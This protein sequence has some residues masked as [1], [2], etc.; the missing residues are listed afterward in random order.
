MTGATAKVA[1]VRLRPPL[2]APLA[3]GIAFLAPALAGCGGSGSKPGNGVAS[4]TPAE[5]VAAAKAA[6]D[7][8]AS[9]HIAGAISEGSPLSLDM[10]LLAGKGGR[11]RITQSGVS[12]DLITLGSTVYIKGSSAFYRRIGG[13]AAAQLFQGKWLK[14]PATAGEFS[15][16]SALTDL[17][18]LIDTTLATH[19]TLSKGATTSVGGVKAIAVKDVTKGGVLYVASTGKP[20]PLEIAR[21]GANG[22]HIVFDRWNQAVT[23][24]PPTNAININQ[25]R[26]GH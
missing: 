23:I 19:G 12:F 11:G 20:Y 25:L 15:S 13:P 10:H 26:S 22:G 21:G 8:A 3:L 7:E 4:K 16:I 2:L 1:A 17:R 6:A 9:V 14:A 24:S 18:K 5:I